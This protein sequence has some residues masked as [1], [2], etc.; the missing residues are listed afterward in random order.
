MF[1]DDA[2]EHG[3]GAGVIPDAVRPDDRDRPGGANLQAIGLA[4]LDTAAR[5][6]L[7]PGKTELLEPLFQIFPRALSNIAAAAFLLFRNRAQENMA[8]NRLAAN[9]AER[10]LRP[11]KLLV[12]IGD[13]RDQRP[14]PAIR[15]ISAFTC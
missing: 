7:C 1:L 6:A 2:F 10:A 9:L 14:L 3:L 5:R 15:A 4:T 12:W 11:V 8:L 13:R